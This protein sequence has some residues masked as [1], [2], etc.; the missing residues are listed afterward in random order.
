[1][2]SKLLSTIILLVLS[3]CFIG[4]N[5]VQRIDTVNDEGKEVMDLDYRDFDLVAGKMAE[6]ILTSGILDNNG[7]KYVISTGQI[8][9]LTTRRIDTPA[10]MV[11]IEEE[12]INSGQAIMTSAVGGKNSLDPMVHN[13]RDVRD[14]DYGDEF[15]DDTISGKGNLI[16]PDLNISG[17]IFHREIVSHEKAELHA[18]DNSA[19]WNSDKRIQ[20][21]YYFQLMI[22]DLSSGLR[23]WQKEILIGKRGNNKAAGYLKTR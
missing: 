19:R 18:N 13:I 7:N 21:E 1:M 17:R 16:A 8:L 3:F 9:N 15:K 12:I 6:S 2:K 4:C 20:R 23:I 14:S 5:E 10:L 11:K 22:T